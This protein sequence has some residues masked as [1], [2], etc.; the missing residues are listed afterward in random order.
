MYMLSTKGP[1]AIT[2]KLTSG[3]QYKIPS[4][5]FSISHLYFLY[6]KNCSIS[7]PKEF[8]GFKLLRVLK[9]KVF[10]STDSDISNLI[11]SCPLLDAVRLRYFEGIN[12][13]NIQS[14]TL[15]I[16][17][18]EGN[19]EDI[20]VDAP[21]LLHMYLTLDD[22]EGHQ[23]VPVQGDRKSYLKQTFGSLTRFTTLSFLDGNVLLA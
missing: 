15:Q 10:A 11:S 19:F 2:I 16:L 22:T 21:N 4:S 14:Q 1:G 17:E 5:L 12:C 8:E 18:I 3:P 13:L 20:R 6:L 7:L 9:L 23:S